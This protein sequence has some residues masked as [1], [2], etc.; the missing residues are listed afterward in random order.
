[1]KNLCVYFFCYF[2]C[3]LQ[4]LDVESQFPDQGLNPR[5][6]SESTNH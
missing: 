3:S 5:G 4:W 1:M 2:C 6:I